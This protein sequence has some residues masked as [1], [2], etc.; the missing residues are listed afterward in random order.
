VKKW[1]PKPGDSINIVD[2]EKKK[3]SYRTLA[4]GLIS[5]DN[6]L[7][8]ADIFIDANQ[9]EIINHIKQV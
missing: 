9:T 2:P 8:K 1:L 7:W 3:D 6:Y 5:Y 4:G